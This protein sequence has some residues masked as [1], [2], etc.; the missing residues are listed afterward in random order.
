MNWHLNVHLRAINMNKR[1]IVPDS[2]NGAKI[3]TFD[4]WL[5]LPPSATIADFGNE[6]LVVE[7]YQQQKCKPR[8]AMS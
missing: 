1:S 2:L 6:K 3:R 7:W 8:Q 4:P 5:E